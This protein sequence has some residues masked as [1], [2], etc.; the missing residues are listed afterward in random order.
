MDNYQ[1]RY[2]ALLVELGE[3][4]HDRAKLEHELSFL[5]GV[6]ASTVEHSLRLLTKVILA[7]HDDLY[8]HNGENGSPEDAI[9]ALYKV[10][11]IVE[12]L[13]YGD[14]RE[15]VEEEEQE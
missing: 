11:S 2:Y 9:D 5:K 6:G 12:K 14:F 7:L 8:L 4:S 15:A 1:N 13:N 10:K 3:A